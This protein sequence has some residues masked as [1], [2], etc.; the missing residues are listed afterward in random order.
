MM[1]QGFMFPRAVLVAPPRKPK[2]RSGA[3]LTLDIIDE[4]HGCYFIE[5]PAFDLK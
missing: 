1:G 2:D 4:T 3:E 5:N